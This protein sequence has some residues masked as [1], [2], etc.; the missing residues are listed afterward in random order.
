MAF[1]VARASAIDLL[2]E[3]VDALRAAPLAT[4]VYHWIGSVPFALAL[5]IFWNDMTRAGARDGTCASEALVLALLLAWMNCW[6]G[7]FA[8]R[9]QRQLARQ[10]QPPWTRRRIWRLIASQIFLG[11]T[12]LAALPLA[13]TITLPMPSTVAFYRNSAVLADREDLDLRQLIAKARK[14]AVPDQRQG[15]GILLLLAILY[16]VLVVNL[17]ILLA[18]LPQ[19]VRV[20]TGYESV[21]SRGGTYFVRNSL[22]WLATLAVAWIAFDPFIQAVYC[23]RYFKLESRETGEDLRAALR[24]TMRRVLLLAVLQIGAPILAW[25]FVAGRPAQ[26]APADLDR[27]I[28]QTLQSSDYAWRLAPVPQRAAGVPWLV[29]VTD[30]LVDHAKAALHSVGDAIDRLVEWL[31]EKFRPASR[32]ASA[33]PPAT[34]LH[35]S[36]YV[37]IAGMLALAAAIAWRMRHGRD[38]KPAHIDTAAGAPVNLRDENLLASQLP[39]DRWMALAED[40]ARQGDLRSALRALYLANLAWLGSGEWIVI[41]PGKTNREYE[42]EV[43]RKARGFPEACSLFAANIVSFEGAWYGMHEVTVGDLELLRQRLQSMKA[44]IAPAELAA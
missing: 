5:L 4:L 13:I 31:I 34:A 23:I 19:L 43:R 7:V 39:E 36:I 21:F 26:L 18:L 9:I 40:C 29:A 42:L 11:G 8:G 2:E 1:P 44:L 12:K 14:L 24:D 38:G 20:L 33:A 22:F 35:W 6:R 10:P 32:T 15:W 30:R 41:H 28:H 3:A 37:L 27:A 25:G 16:L 17:A